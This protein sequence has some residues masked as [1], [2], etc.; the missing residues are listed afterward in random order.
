ISVV[1]SDDG[2]GFDPSAVTK[3]G[4]LGLAGMRERLHA[5]KGR[6]RVQSKPGSGTKIRVSIPIPEAPS[7]EL[8]ESRA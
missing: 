8:V 6:I 3:S 1:I 7:G 4:G 5:V 2:C